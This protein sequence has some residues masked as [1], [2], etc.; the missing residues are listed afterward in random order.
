[1][2]VK[3]GS[4]CIKIGVRIAAIALSLAL[5]FVWSENSLHGQARR[6]GRGDQ[7]QPARPHNIEEKTTPGEYDDRPFDIKAAQLPRGYRGHDPELIYTKIIERKENVGKS[8]FE[9][10]ERYRARVAQ[11]TS[12]PLAGGL[13]LSSTFAFR[14][15]PIES[16]YSIDQRILHL[17]CEASPILENGQEDT[18][19]RGFK[20]KNQPQVDN[21]YTY[22]NAQGR[23]V[24]IEEIKFQEYTVAFANYGEFQVDRLLLPSIQQAL[25]KE[26][27]KGKPVVMDERTEREFIV[28]S[29][30]LTPAEAKQI[31]DRIMVLAVCNLTDPYATSDTVSEKPTPDRMR[32]YFGQYFYINVKLLELWFYNLDTGAILMKIGPKG[33]LRLP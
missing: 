10:V 25:E 23:K 27:K 22:K 15:K 1:L 7:G 20:I 6:G 24:E 9:S 12:L 5:L 11:E 18:T 33:A 31:K 14:F 21:R 8:E 17:F 2:K 4:G 32:E 28:G 3:V 26:A 16:F 13:D 19:R 29:I 30:G